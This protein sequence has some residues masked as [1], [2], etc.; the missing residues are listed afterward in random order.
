MFNLLIASNNQ[1]KIKE[2]EDMFLGYDVKVFSPKELGI[3]VNP[4]ENGKTYEANSLI[5]AE[6]LQKFSNMAIIADDSGLN[7]HALHD[8]PGI[9]SARFAST[10]GGNILANPLLIKMLE[11]YEDK[12]ADF[13]CVITLLN[14]E[15][16]P[17]VFKGV[18]PGRILDKPDGDSGFGYDPIFFSNE[19]GCSFGTCPEE[20]KN[21][22]SHRAKALNQLLN[23]LLSKKLIKKQN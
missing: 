6:A 23:Y 19:A 1:H 17:L 13:T 7:V 16:K 2:F 18:C 21:K 8:F 12:S 11:P 4:N 9:C 10:N 3:E 15:D 20:I 5:K 22:Y 14:V